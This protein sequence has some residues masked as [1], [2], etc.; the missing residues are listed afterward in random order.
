MPALHRA[1]KSA[2]GSSATQHSWLCSPLTLEAW[3]PRTPF[4]GIGDSVPNSLAF[5]IALILKFVSCSSGHYAGCGSMA[6]C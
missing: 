1:L 2:V 6:R 3:P 5:E 4:Y